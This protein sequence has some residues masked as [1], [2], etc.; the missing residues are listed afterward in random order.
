MGSHYPLLI[1]G[2]TTSKQHTAVKIA[3]A[4]SEP[5]VHVVDASRVVGVMSALLDDTRKAKLDAD[6]RKTQ[7]R[8]RTLHEAKLKTPLLPYRK[9]LGNRLQVDWRPEDAP[10]PPFVGTRTVEPDLA[11]LRD[12]IDWTF[13]F[14]A[15]ELKG[16]Y[17]QYSTTRRWVRPL[18][19]CSRS[20]RRCWIGPCRSTCSRRVASTGTS[21]PIPTATTSSST[22]AGSSTVSGSRPIAARESRTSGSLLVAPLE[23][24][25]QEHVGAFAVSAGFGADELAKAYEAEHDDYR[26][27]VA[28]AL[29]DR[30]AEASRGTSTSR[31]AASGTPPTSSSP[32]RS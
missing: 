28:K 27:I 21:P 24:D 29:A 5:V 22:E 2:A 14:T 7:D 12:Y 32:A 23:S 6:N 9:A 13:F 19:S 15:W 30:L 8:L 20:G 18:G 10:A 17:P 4:Y 31:S 25:V 16:S 26:A 1:G 11:V 3:L